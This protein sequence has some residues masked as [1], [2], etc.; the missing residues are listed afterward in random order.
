M[1]RRALGGAPCRAVVPLVLLTAEG[2]PLASG[3]PG[4]GARGQKPCTRLQVHRTGS[5]RQHAPTEGSPA[6]EGG[7][8]RS[9]GP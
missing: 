3:T 8:T 5:L 2:V 4:R 9:P 1:T 7:L 6:S